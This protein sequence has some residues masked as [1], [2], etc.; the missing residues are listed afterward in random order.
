MSKVF[1]VLK[2]HGL[3]ALL[4]FVFALGVALV[5][6]PLDSASGMIVKVR[7]QVNIGDALAPTLAACVIGFGALLMLF[8]RDTG[9]T[10]AVTRKNFTFI[11]RLGLV[12][13]VGF[14]L[15][16]WVAKPR[17]GSGDSS[18]TL[19]SA[20]AVYVIRHLKHIGSLAAC[21]SS[22]VIAFSQ[23]R[24]TAQ[25]VLIGVLA[26]VLILCYDLLLDDLLLPQWGCV[27]G[28]LTISGLV[29]SRC[30]KGRVRFFFG[31][32]ISIT[33]L[34]VLRGSCG[35]LVVRR[36]V[37]RGQ[38]RWRFLPVLISTFGFNAD[39]LL[40][41]MGFLIGIMKGATAGGAAC[42]FVQYKTPDA[43]MT[44]DGYPMAQGQSAKSL[45]LCISVLSGD[46]FSDIVLIFCVLFLAVLW[47]VI[48]I[49]LKNRAFDPPRFYR[50]WL[51]VCWQRRYLDGAWPFGGLYR[52][53]RFLSTSVDGHADPCTGVCNFAVLGVLILGEV[54]KSL[55]DLWQKH[56]ATQAHQSVTEDHDQKLRRADIR[57]IAPYIGRSALIGTVI[58]ALPGI[59]STLAATMG[60]S[61]GARH[62]AR[63]Y[64]S[65]PQFGQG[66]PEGIAATEAANSAV[67][68]ANLIPVLSLGI[69]G[70][71]AAV[72]LILATESI[73]GFN[74]GPG[75]FKFT[76]YTV[77]PELVAAFGLS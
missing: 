38:W 58:G 33:I 54:F 72:F 68:G 49:C 22:R 23:H 52:R 5:W 24:L 59:G 2:A 56:H 37:L 9:Q 7:R 48:L 55:E 16:R 75:V 13:L 17:S 60:Y 18:R 42:Y 32:S 6:V 50:E 35:I 40:P 65:K 73:S 15:V 44:L 53:R 47:N 71:A 45:N 4:C 25:A 67:S 74:P 26:A 51:G 64:P 36:P 27:M 76:S 61:S 3:L 63:R 66:A 20:I 10:P 39:V 11:L 19:T 1:L 43:Y 41:V 77:N 62:H 12:L 14:S 46:T 57:A 29:F 34:M 30:S 70:N 31:L 28:V 69:P 21:L 8:E